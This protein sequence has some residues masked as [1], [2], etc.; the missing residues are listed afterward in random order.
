DVKVSALN[1]HDASLSFVK[2][3]SLSNYDF[4]FKQKKADTTKRGTKMNLAELADKL[5]NSVL[6]KIPENMK[7]AN[8]EASYVDDSAKQI[9]TVPK[10][11][12]DDGDLSS[13]VKINGNEAVWHVLGRVRP[14]KK[15]LYFKV[16]AEGKAVELPV[17]K[18]K[19]GLTLKFDTL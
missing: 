7:L 11:I 15:Q 17:I 12:I 13:T 5:I 4:L 18:K 3:D 14:S 8:F 16:Y 9:I 1:L 19:Y 6:Y 10:A 2:K